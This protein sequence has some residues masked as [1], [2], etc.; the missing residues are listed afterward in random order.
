VVNELFGKILTDLPAAPMQAIAADSI[1][2]EKLALKIA[3]IERR[4][5]ILECVA[6][7]LRTHLDAEITTFP[8]LESWSDSSGV[9][10][11]IIVGGV[12]ALKNVLDPALVKTIAS[13]EIPII[14]LAD[15]LDRGD[16]VE[17]MR[18]GV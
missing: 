18:L 4:T 6:R 5:L 17:S 2:S 8:D 12:D 1:F 16:I 7:S 14:L 10:N 9:P 15:A 3:L 11:L 13:K